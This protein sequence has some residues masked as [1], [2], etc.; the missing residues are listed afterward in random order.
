MIPRYSRPEM[1]RVWSE[2]NKFASWL[3]VEIA[4]VQA[5]ADL[6]AVPRD[7]ADRIAANARFRIEDIERYERE[8]HH[9]MN[10]FLRSVA[11]S[12]GEESRWV[13]LGLTSYDTEDPALALRLVEA[14]DILA[15][16]LRKLEEAIAARA[17]EH[18][19]TLCMGRTHG[20]HA[21]PITFG[22]KLLNWLDEVRRDQK[23]LA[24][25]REDVAVGKLSGPVGSHATVPLELEE[26]VCA[27]LGLGVDSAST[28]VVS[29]DRHAHFVQTLALI[30]ASLE[31]FATEVRH[32]QRTEV[33]EAEEPFSTGQM[34][35]HL[36]PLEG[37]AQRHQQGSSS[38]P[39]KRNPEKCERVCGLARVLRANSIAALEN[40]ALWHERD[41]SQ[42]SVERIILPD[43]C[44]ALDYMLALFTEIVRGLVVYPE[45]MRRNMELTHGVVFSQRVLLALVE[46]GM[47]RQDAYPIVQRAGHVA[48]DEGRPFRETIAE[49]PGVRDLLSELEL[50][51]LFDYAYFT[52]EVDKS[53]ARMGLLGE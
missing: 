37:G 16:D 32:L 12:L 3:K 31:R 35:L 42:S 52:R 14:A 1:A 51:A 10:A 25:A 29:R 2:E 7:D 46:K 34:D 4:A 53:F 20:M 22:L 15:D 21:E 6:G 48:L 33:G 5:W 28:Q 24:A 13:H 9:D 44:L 18:K 26:R 49:Q 41:I 17:I 19:D 30:G 50:D 23:R 43:S 38:M 47:S 27:R 11:D 45:R 8:M 39:H 36:R 40:V